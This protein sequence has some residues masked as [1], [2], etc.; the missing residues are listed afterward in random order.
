M[1]NKISATFIGIMQSVSKKLYSLNLY[2]SFKNG[3]D[4][5]FNMIEIRY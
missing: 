4:K 2:F 3:V 1:F 5:I